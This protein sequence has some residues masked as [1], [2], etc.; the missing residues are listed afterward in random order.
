MKFLRL[1]W[2]GVSICT[3]VVVIAFGW[4]SPQFL[5]AGQASAKKQQDKT[6]D[7]TDASREPQGPALPAK[8][9]VEGPITVKNQPD[10]E[11]QKRDAEQRAQTRF[12]N[13]LQIWT[14]FFAGLAALG[15]IGAYF[16]NR[17]SANAA[18]KQITLLNG[19]ISDSKADALEQRRIATDGLVEIRRTADAATTQSDLMRKQLVGTMGAVVS[20]V[21]AQTDTTSLMVKIINSGG[22]DA[23]HLT[24]AVRITPVVLPALERLADT[25]SH[26]FRSP[27]VQRNNEGGSFHRLYA[28]PP[29]WLAPRNWSDWRDSKTV[30]V[31][32]TFSCD[33]GFGDPISGQDRRVYLPNWKYPVAGGERAG[34]PGFHP[35]EAAADYWRDISEQLRTGRNA[36]P[37][38]PHK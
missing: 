31:D 27:A 30:L 4:R 1:A 37:N 19:Q 24:G 36:Q 9:T 20:C 18:E 10:P 7:K 34:N 14:L 13:I 21:I 11:Q 25:I 5:Q 33:N 35:A 16:A 38:H 29:E 6:R 22:V 3:L 32:V 8:I 28:F 23:K 26:Q 17:R 12:S 15:A 2:H